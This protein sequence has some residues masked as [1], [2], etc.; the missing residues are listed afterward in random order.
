MPAI[1]LLVRLGRFG[2]IA[3]ASALLLSSATHAAQQPPTDAQAQT[4]PSDKQDDRAGPPSLR[5]KDDPQPA[6]GKAA[7]GSS[8]GP[9]QPAGQP[10][11]VAPAE[12]N[13]PVTPPADNAPPLTEQSKLQLLRY[14]D[15]EYAKVL[16]PLPGGKDGYHLKAGA[17]LNQDSLRKALLAGGAALNAGDSVQITRVEFHDREIQLDINNGPK[18]KTS[19]RD[20][21][22][23]QVG[24]GLPV[25]T[26]TTTTPENGPVVPQKLGATIFLDFERPVPEMTGDQLKAY[27]GRVLDFSKRSAAVQY[28]D[29][30]PPQMREAIAAKRAEV[31][32]DHDMVT[33]AMGRP[34]R[35]VRERDAEGNDLEDWIYGKPPAKTTFVTFQGDKVVRVTQ[36]P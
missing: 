25:S 35:K 34:E 19:W 22:H 24:A 3:F 11:S 21:V 23:L 16:T 10:I 15:G 31:G 1:F 5:H 2:P 28:V 20:R 12:S 26:S 33:A 14:V 18:G 4:Q 13:Q 27:L 32:M 36:Y 30:L 7:A 29:S 9:A 17:P 6:S 8:K